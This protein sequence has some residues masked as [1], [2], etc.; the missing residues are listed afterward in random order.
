MAATPLLGL[1][2]DF[3]KTM[4]W[5]DSDVGGFEKLPLPHGPVLAKRLMETK[6]QWTDTIDMLFQEAQKLGITKA[7]I[8]SSYAQLQ[9]GAELDEA[10]GELKGISKLFILS[11]ANSYSIEAILRHAS[12]ISLGDFER[13]IT[14]PAHFQEDGALRVKRHTVSP[15]NCKNGCALNLCKGKEMRE[16]VLPILKKEN[17][18]VKRIVYVGDGT[19]DFCPS[20]EL[21]PGDVVMVR[22]GL[23]LDKLLKNSAEHRERI[24]AKVVFWE[25][26]PELASLLRAVG[27]EVVRGRENE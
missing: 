19:N 17:E 1:V 21:G 3:D 8:D 9:V 2:F 13:V 5:T 7:D 20:T 23:G 24:K 12:H 22:A 27:E 11:D 18:Q 26:Y 6:M 25:S 16:V 10:L 15:H 14:N 4:I